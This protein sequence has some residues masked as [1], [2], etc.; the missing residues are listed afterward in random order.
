[1]LPV[2][3]IVVAAVPPML[4]IWPRWTVPP[5]VS[6]ITSYATSTWVF[7]V[8]VWRS[9]VKI[10][11]VQESGDPLQLVLS[12]SP[13]TMYRFSTPAIAVPPWCDIRMKDLV[14]SAEVDNGSAGFAVNALMAIVAVLRATTVAPS[15]V[16]TCHATVAALVVA[17]RD[18]V[19]VLVI[20]PAVTAHGAANVPRTP[21]NVNCS[22][23]IEVSAVSLCSPARTTKL[24]LQSTVPMTGAADGVGLPALKVEVPLTTLTPLSN[25]ATNQDTVL[26][27]VTLVPPSIARLLVRRMQVTRWLELPLLVRVGKKTKALVGYG[28]SRVML[29]TVALGTFVVPEWTRFRIAASAAEGARH[30]SPSATAATRWHQRVKGVINRSCRIRSNPSATESEILTV[31]NS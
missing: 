15:I 4:A 30:M 16:T 14:E 6:V 26:A 13:L 21:R 12:K 5:S 7:A 22:S 10:T 19:S 8:F 29:T 25:S 9:R 20:V 31:V 23:L 1:M 11:L 24:L 2:T 3:P 28:S 18:R 27:L 17:R